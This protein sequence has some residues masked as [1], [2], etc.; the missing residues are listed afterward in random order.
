[1]SKAAVLMAE[2]FEESETMTIVDLL[3]RAQIECTTF[4]LT[5]PYV[6]GMQHLIL[7]ADALFSDEIE[8]YDML[9]L[10]GGRPG[11]ENLL[12]DA[13]V[14]EMIRKFDKEGKLL[15]AMCSGTTVLAEAG[16]INGKKMTG[17]TGYAEK[18]PGAIFQE[19]VAVWDQ[20]LISS[21]GPA[22]VYPFAFKIIEA[23]GIDPAPYKERLLYTLA[24]GQ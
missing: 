21:Q 2:G 1:M 19:D 9:I 22:T 5:G 7:K 15:A 6:E 20:N 17:Y 12:K 23:F 3:R 13:R 4:S 10:P 24:G 18:L 8:E 14:I 11:K 16:V